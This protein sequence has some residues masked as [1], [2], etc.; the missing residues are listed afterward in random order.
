MKTQILFVTIALLMVTASCNERIDVKFR[1][2]YKKTTA[3][4][5]SVKKNLLKTKNTNGS[6]TRFGS[7]MGTITPT[8][9]TATFMMLKFQDSDS[10]VWQYTYLHFS[11]FPSA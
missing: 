8:K 7:F 10:D 3:N 6:F 1:T 4:Q 5:V 2:V 11:V 9:V